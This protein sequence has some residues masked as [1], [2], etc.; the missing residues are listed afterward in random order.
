METMEKYE[1]YIKSKISTD[2]FG[3]KLFHPMILLFKEKTK[4]H[5]CFVFLAGFEKLLCGFLIDK[6]LQQFTSALLLP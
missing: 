6:S 2:I 1:N 3:T 4:T 5:Q